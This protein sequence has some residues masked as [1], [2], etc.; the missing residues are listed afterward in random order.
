MSITMVATVLP[1]KT[2]INYFFA[3]CT[4]LTN[5]L[6]RVS[7]IM[8]PPKDADRLNHELGLSNYGSLTDLHSIFRISFNTRVSFHKL[9]SALLLTRHTGRYLSL[10]LPYCKFSMSNS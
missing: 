10:L 5:I 3:Y 1:T 7:P 2:V 4:D 8:L 6:Q 9:V